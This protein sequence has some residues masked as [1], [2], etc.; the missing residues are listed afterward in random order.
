MSVYLDLFNES[1]ITADN[2]TVTSSMIVTGT[3]DLSGAIITGLPVDD[4]T[5]G[6]ST[7]LYVK[8]D[9]ISTDKI[10]DAAVIDSKIVSMAGNKLT[11]TV[12]TDA[13]QEATIG[14]GIDM[15]GENI[16]TDQWTYLHN[17]DQDVDTSSSPGFLKIYCKKYS[18][19]GYES[20]L[21]EI[22]GVLVVNTSG[23]QSLTTSIVNQLL[24]I[25]VL[26]ISSSQWGYV[27]NM[28][29]NVSSSSSPTFSGITTPSLSYGGYTITIPSAN[30]V[31]VL[32]TSS[33]QSITSSQVS[34][35]LN[36]G[37]Q[38][39]SATQWGYLSVLDQSVSTSSSPSFAS[40]SLSS[41]ITDSITENTV[42]HGVTIMGNTIK[43]NQWNNL[44]M[45]NV[46]DTLVGRATTDTL[47][48]KTLTGNIAS[49][50]SNSGTITLPTGTK[51]LSTLAGTETLSNKTL[52]API[53][54]SIINTGTLTLPTS[55]DTL[56]GRAT[57]DTLTNKTLTGNIASS[58]S[59]SGTVT[60]PSGPCTLVQNNSGLQSLTTSEV[61]QLVNI[62]TNTIS[63]STW[64]N[65][66]IINQD[67]DTSSAP[68]FPLVN[69]SG[70]VSFSGTIGF[71]PDI[72]IVSTTLLNNLTGL[73]TLSSAEVTQ[74]SNIDSNV[75]SSTKWGYVAAMDQS[76]STS[77]NVSFGD[78]KTM[79]LKK[80]S[81][82]DS[83]IYVNNAGTKTLTLKESDG[84]VRSNGSIYAQDLRS[85][86][87]GS[88]YL[89][90]YGDPAQGVL[91]QLG[92]N[93]TQISCYANMSTSLDFTSPSLITDSITEKT[94]S[95]GVTIASNTLKNNTWTNGAVVTTFPGA[96][97][98]LVGKA[99]TDTLTNKTLTLPIIASISNSGTITI[100]TGTLTLATITGTETLTNKTLTTPIIT[101]I[102]NSGTITI[103]TGTLTLSTLTGTE[104]LTNKSLQDSTTSIVDNGDATKKM[105]F[106]CSGITTATTRTLTVPN[107]SGT[108]L[109]D[110]SSI[111]LQDSTTTIYDNSDTSKIM[112]FECSGITTATTR[113]VTAYNGS[114]VMV[115]DAGSQT[116]SDKT[117][118]N[119][120]TVMQTITTGTQTSYDVSGC[121]MLRLTTSGGNITLNSLAGGVSGQI[122]TVF[123]ASSANTATIK[124][125]GTGTQK[126]QCSLNTDLVMMVGFGGFTMCFDGT[127]WFQY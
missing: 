51:T 104:T 33:I 120:R 107:A 6:F 46:T 76:V 94:A 98:T 65:L 34:Q 121:S 108:I 124:N 21:P 95:H 3:I 60:L 61:S 118:T 71:L 23:I 31:I 68:S 38:T 126:I 29:Q 18:Y 62:G 48:N 116:I 24:N 99:T 7:V 8:D 74:L 15:N 4:T 119:I 47:T 73:D 86:R 39:I 53:I 54:S 49:S 113:T 96:S 41:I 80:V 26:T 22:S 87:S 109:L 112:K 45:P 105:Q 57:T 1:N 127:T 35:I 89:E 114:G 83:T 92:P 90:L 115:L 111:A 36:L 77:S 59:N 37:V 10:Q 50:F 85:S 84:S 63:N 17:L 103:P 72:G 75:I 32:N 27:N 44:T 19:S 93:P 12:V 28:N 2:V 69:T 122:I 11:G 123:K 78:V 16:S 40:I 5:I 117:L 125:N 88:S 58:F 82:A 66:S 43:S 81:A 97:D 13:I 79:A 64:G 20:D 30:G 52:T 101:S 55:T 106:E 100:P 67:L 14:H 91:M 70:M 56:I 102:S 25:G 9:G 110:S 42:G